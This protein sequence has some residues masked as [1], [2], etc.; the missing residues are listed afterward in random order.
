MTEPTPAEIEEALEYFKD[1]AEEPLLGLWATHVF[2][3]KL[4]AAYEQALKRIK[5][6]EDELAKRS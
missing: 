3:K 6:L 5:E 4:A 2:G 1:H